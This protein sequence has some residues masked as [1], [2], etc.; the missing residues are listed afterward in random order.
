MRTRCQ[1]DE[2]ISQSLAGGGE[3]N[4]CFG[5]RNEDSVQVGI[6]LIQIAEAEGG[7]LL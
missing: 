3:G 1:A 5:G 7:Y 4:L 6:Q 2:D